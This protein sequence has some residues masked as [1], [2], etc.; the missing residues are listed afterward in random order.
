MPLHYGFDR[1]AV[2]AGQPRLEAGCPLGEQLREGLRLPGEA[3]GVL[4]AAEELAEIGAETAVQDGS[5]PTMGQ[6]SRMY[7]ART[8]TVRRSTRLAVSSC[9]VER[10]P[11]QATADRLGRHDD[12]EPGRLQD[13]DRPGA[14]RTAARRPRWPVRASAPQPGQRRAASPVS[15]GRVAGP[16]RHSD[17]TG[18]PPC[19]WPCR[20]ARGSRSYSS[21]LQLLDL[22][23][24]QSGGD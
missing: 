21:A 14:W 4:V 2:G 19:R 18:T 17:A 3:V 8:S 10:D 16:G 1:T 20:P 24:E 23:L 22:V 5:R 7:G 11:G 6:P 9:P 13:T 12:L 15:S